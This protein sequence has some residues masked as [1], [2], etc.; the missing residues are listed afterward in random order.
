MSALIGAGG[1]IGASLLGGSSASETKGLPKYAKK[2]Q[3]QQIAQGNAAYDRALATAP[4]QGSDFY[5]PIDPLTQAGIDQTGIYAQG[6]G[7]AAANQVAGYGSQAL[8][9]GGAGLNQAAGALYGAATTDPT[10]ANISAAG[11]YAANPYLD[12]LIDASSR[13]VVRNLTE[14]V[15]PQSARS[16]TM[17]GNGNSTRT[18]I[19]EGIALRGA[20]DRI[21]DIA[22]EIRSGAYSQGL[23]LAEQAR[24]G[25]L[26]ALQSAGGLYGNLGAQGLDAAGQGQQMNFNNLDAMVRA[27]QISQADAQ[28]ILNGQ[29]QANQYQLDLL[30]KKGAATGVSSFNPGTTTTTQPAGGISGALQAGVGGA[31]TGLGLYNTYQQISRQQTPSGGANNASTPNFNY[32]LY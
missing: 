16:A 19:A 3:K 11:R 17:G 25:N 9:Q 7:Q 32:G 22:A 23:N 4:T 5:D 28:G 24:L 26:G 21:G 31:S 20:Q 6:A 12:S 30:A 8:A 2:A 15:L 10:N 1:T 14:G 27:G 29:I 13:D 18:G